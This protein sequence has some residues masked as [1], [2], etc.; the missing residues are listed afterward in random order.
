M[1][2][3]VRIKTADGLWLEGLLYSPARPCGVFTLFHSAFA[4]FYEGRFID[5]FGS[6]L[7]SGGWAFLSVNTRGRDYYAD[8]MQEGSPCNPN[9]REIGGIRESFDESWLDIDAWANFSRSIANGPSI[10][11]GHS[12]GAMKVIF[13]ISQKAVSCDGVGL[14]SPADLWGYVRKLSGGSFEMHREAGVQAFT[15]W[16]AGGRKQSP[17][18]LM[19]SEAYF[20]PISCVSFGSLFEHED[21]TGMFHLQSD[22]DVRP[23]GLEGISIPLAISFGTERE[24]I[25]APPQSYIAAFTRRIPHSNIESCIIQGADHN[26]H[27]MEEQLVNFWKS[28]LVKIFS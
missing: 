28:W 11:V 20:S 12:L 1:S 9:F 23:A 7:L 10:L 4:N 16:D 18:E 15:E 22:G 24:V 25:C 14:I 8:F 6:R 2:E 5:V 19:P 17:S 26:Y 3:L 27:G 13:A 21:V